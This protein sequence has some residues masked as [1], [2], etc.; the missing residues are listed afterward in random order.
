M[1]DTAENTFATKNPEFGL[2]GTMACIG[3][4]P[5]TAWAIALPLIAQATGCSFE[6]ARDLMDSTHGRHFA[7]EVANQLARRLSLDTAIRAAIDVFQGWRIDRRVTR[8]YGIPAGLPY[9]T[10]WAHHFEILGDVG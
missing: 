1:K 9:L 6:A 5:E 2:W 7:D 10:G 3:Q 4:P 8:Q